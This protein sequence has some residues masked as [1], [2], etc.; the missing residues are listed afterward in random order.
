ML[1]SSLSGH[2]GWAADRL[3]R[4]LCGVSLEL[5]MSALPEGVDV[6][7]PAAGVAVVAFT[8]EHDLDTRAATSALLASLVEDDGAVILDFSN[9]EF[10]DS[11]ILAVVAEANRKASERGTIFRLQLGTLRSWRRP[12]A[13]AEYWKK[14]SVLRRARK[15]SRVRASDLQ[16]TWN[17]IRPVMS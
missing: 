1:V 13:S 8:G 10:V 17:D 14:W 7:R 12:S 11:S 9:A 3:D 6:E 15:Y 4:A 16:Q 2:E 5:A